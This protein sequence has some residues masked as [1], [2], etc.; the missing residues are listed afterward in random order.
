MTIAARMMRITISI[1]DESAE[2]LDK[3]ADKYT[4]NRS[5]QIEHMVKEEAAKPE[6][7]DI[8]GEEKKT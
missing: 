3:L 8:R 4:R 6:N 5:Q 2:L 1:S 7:A